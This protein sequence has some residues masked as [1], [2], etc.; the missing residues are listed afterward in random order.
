MS[1]FLL[2]STDPAWLPK[3]SLS[4]W[5]EYVYCPPPLSLVSKL[6]Q[7]SSEQSLFLTIICSNFCV[8]PV[9]ILSLELALHSKQWSASPQYFYVFSP[10]HCLYVSSRPPVTF[11]HRNQKTT[12]EILTVGCARSQLYVLVVVLF[13]YKT[14]S[15]IHSF[16]FTEKQSSY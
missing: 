8:F 16:S 11:S 14:I 9:V 5:Q 10:F 12:A 13:D 1:W 3:L 15:C 6:Q 4:P 7:T 2:Q